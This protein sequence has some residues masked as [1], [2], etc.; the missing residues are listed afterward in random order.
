MSIANDFLNGKIVVQTI[1]AKGCDSFLEWMKSVNIKWMSGDCPTELYREKDSWDD[2]YYII[3]EP[4][5]I[6]NGIDH[7]DKY[8]LIQYENIINWE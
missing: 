3:E 1:T 4:L 6:V 2:R 5:R 7:L 8:E